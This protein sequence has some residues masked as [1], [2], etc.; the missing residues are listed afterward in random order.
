MSNGSE[1]LYFPALGG[2]YQSLWKLV[3]LILRLATGLLLVP[4]GFWKL[5]YVGGPGLTGV[6][7]FLEKF[8][9]SP[10]AFWAPA[11]TTVEI[12]GGILIAIGLFTRPVALIAF[13]EM[14]FI[15]QYHSRYG[16]FFSIPGGGMEYA[17]L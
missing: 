1:R 4:H 11:L 14:L 2:F 12:A 13:I 10:G 8:G 17:V 3:E 16:W 5:G 15:V 7:K 6:E 9:Y